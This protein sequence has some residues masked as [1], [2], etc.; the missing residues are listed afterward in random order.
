MYHPILRT[1]R[2]I[3][4]GPSP[5]PARPFSVAIACAVT[6]IGIACSSDQESKLSKKNVA[7]K[8]SPALVEADKITDQ[9]YDLKLTGENGAALALFKRVG[10][11]LVKTEGKDSQPVASN[12]D[13]QATIYLRTG[14]Y[15]R[16]GQLY[17]EARKILDKTKPKDKRL[18]EGIGRRLAILDELGQRNII[19]AEPLE[20]KRPKDA[21]ADAGTAS[22]FPP[23]ENAQKVFGRMC[24][25]LNGCLKGPPRP[26]TIRLVITG[27]GQII[28]AQTRGPM[29]STKAAACLEK[30]ILEVAP[31]FKESLPKFK[32]CFRNFTY[33]FIVGE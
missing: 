2:P 3:D 23:I 26:V 28:K 12:L 15:A 24:K 27:K 22:Y 1:P 31:E 21:G 5:A 4:S 18:A 14:N 7:P 13:D 33:P 6:V 29:G 25:R 32:A 8:K 11:M 19:C 17:R 30:K 16:A 10:D 9:A 20:P